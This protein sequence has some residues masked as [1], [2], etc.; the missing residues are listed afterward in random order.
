MKKV[1]KFLGALVL[2][3]VAVMTLTACNGDE[4]VSEITIWAWD[5]NFNIRALNIAAEY[6][7]HINPELSVNI[8]ESAQGDIIQQLNTMLPSGTD[9]G[10]PNIVLI[11]DYRAQVFLQ[12]FPGMFYAVAEYINPADFSP[13]KIPMTSLN[14]VQYGVPFDTGVSGF[15]VRTDVLEQAGFTVADVTN[16]DWN[17]LID[18]AIE[19]RE[20]T[21]LPMLTVDPS[22]LAIVRQMLQTAGLW[23]TLEDGITP[24]IADNEGIAIAFEVF[25]R[26]ITEGISLPVTDWG[27]F[28]G[29]FNSGDVWSVP[30][31]N[32]ITAS[33]MNAPEQAGNWAVV[34]FPRM[35]GMPAVNATNLGGSSWYVLNINGRESAAEFLAATFGS[36][37]DFYVSLLNEIGAMGTF[38]PAANAPEFSQHV[39]F[40]AGQQIYSYFQKWATQIPQVNFGLHTYAIEDILA[41]AMQEF[42]G[43]TDISTVLRNAQA[44]ADSQLNR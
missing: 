2:V 34:P 38:M 7:A 22:D 9:I 14:G 26:L 41:I 28:V 40:F 35:P 32:W 17:E 25:S 42:L 36:S 13:Y 5:P 33:V 31:G 21:G 30:T 12:A 43:G 16:I 18:I 39:D 8:V 3:M 1:V 27:G 37:T 44:Q 11:E 15:F 10:L 24:H 23:Y 20:V 4:D 29:G 19:V 6:Y